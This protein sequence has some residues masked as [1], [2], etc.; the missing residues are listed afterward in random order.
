MHD[1]LSWRLVWLLLVV[2]NDRVKAFLPGPEGGGGALRRENKRNGRSHI[3]ARSLMLL[4]NAEPDAPANNMKLLLTE[5]EDNRSSHVVFPGGGI[6][7]YWQAGVV[8][9]LREQGYDLSMCTFT[10]A[11][12]GALTAT[13]TSTDVDFYKATDLALS[14][15]A[16]A[17]VWDRRGGLQGVWGPMIEEWLDNLLPSSIEEYTKDS[18]LSLLVT[19]IPSFGKSKIS[20]F[21]DRNDLI[22]CNRAS[23]HLVSLKAHTS[24]PNWEFTL[25][26]FFDLSLHFVLKLPAFFQPWFLDGKLTFDFR[27]RP[28]IDGSFLSNESHYLSKKNG[29][30]SDRKKNIILDFTDDPALQS[31]GGFDIV[32]ALS[33]KGIYGLLDQGKSFAKYKEE[34]GQFQHLVKIVT[35]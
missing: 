30:V 21:T 24:D 7:F 6:F 28:H 25:L 11:S 17:G 1:R 23:V 34:K 32:E 18:R 15:A 19:P 29:E 13:L 12:A 16:D 4:A 27:Q 33:P 8:C 10:G 9:Y 14:L 3:G 5:E 20:Q 26:W 35:A 31:R 2:A 22:Q